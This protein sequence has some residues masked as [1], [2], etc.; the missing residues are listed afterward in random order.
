MRL[1]NLD[2]IFPEADDLQVLD[3]ANLD[4]PLTNVTTL[5]VAVYSNVVDYPED[6]TKLP[7]TSDTIAYYEPTEGKTGGLQPSEAPPVGEVGPK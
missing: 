5:K 3:A 6:L 7:V 1:A 2:L 4:I